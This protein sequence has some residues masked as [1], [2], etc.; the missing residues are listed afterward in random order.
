MDKFVQVKELQLDLS[1]Q[2]LSKESQ[3]V[4]SIQSRKKES[5]AGGR[6]L[7]EPFSIAESSIA[8]GVELLRHANLLDWRGIWWFGA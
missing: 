5:I 7:P 6:T 1:Q 2:S 8:V 3:G 4:L